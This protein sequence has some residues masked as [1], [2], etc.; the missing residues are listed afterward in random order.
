MKLFYLFFLM[1]I[2]ILNIYA[3]ENNTSLNVDE[4][5]G[6][7]VPLDVTLLDEE[8]KEVTLKEIIDKPT[9]LTLN[10]FRCTG[11]CTPLLNGVAKAVKE[12]DM[13]S[14]G[15]D[16]QIVTISF[17]ETDSYEVAKKKRDNFLDLIKKSEK[18]NG[19]HFLTG[20]A[21]NTKLVS[22]SVGFYFK[23]ENDQFIHPG[24]IIFLSSKGKIIRYSYGVEFLKAEIETGI[25]EAKN[26]TPSIS[27]R[28]FL[29]FCFS[30]DPEGRKYVFSFNKFFALFVTFLCV[31]FLVSLLIIRRR[32][33]K[34][35]GT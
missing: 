11:I 29:P 20:K 28:K 30:Y 2:F 9:I 22:D 31:V 24:V 35:E 17:D 16:Y 15:K 21:Q 32:K 14:F 27:I 12:V 25:L 10:Y 26:E 33:E 34:N 7:Y 6:Q 18:K 1:P 5:I 13:F 3:E 8:G 23:K 4:K 19:W